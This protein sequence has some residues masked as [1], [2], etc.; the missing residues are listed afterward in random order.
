MHNFPQTYD[1]CNTDR[2]TM[3]WTN[4][5]CIQRHLIKIWTEFGRFSGKHTSLCCAKTDWVVNMVI[6]FSTNLFYMKLS[7]NRETC[8]V[9]KAAAKHVHI[10]T[11]WQI[12]DRV[13]VLCPT[14]HK[15][16]HLG[17]V[18]LSQSLGLT[19]KTKSNTKSKHAFVTKYTVT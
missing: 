17:N 13:K 10:L 8:C 15:V 11:D 3:H 1:T 16:G 14:W 12:I 18:N 4:Y 6:F 19:V 5:T 2:T 9:F 7:Y